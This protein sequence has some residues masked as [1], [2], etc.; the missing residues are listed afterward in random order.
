V[1]RDVFYA[2]CTPNAVKRDVFREF[3]GQ[4]RAKHRETQYFSQV[5]GIN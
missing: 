1:K 3:G 2:R 5:F 4:A